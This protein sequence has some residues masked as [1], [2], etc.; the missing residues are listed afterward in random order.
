M[1][2]TSISMADLAVRQ[3]LHFIS[4][5]SQFLMGMGMY[6]ATATALLV[7]TLNSAVALIPRAGEAL[8]VPA[9]IIVAAFVLLSSAEAARWSNKWSERNLGIGFA[10]LVLAMSVLTVAQASGA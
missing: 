7:I 6:A 4:S 3:N 8:D 10:G 1:T 2:H 9:T 5:P